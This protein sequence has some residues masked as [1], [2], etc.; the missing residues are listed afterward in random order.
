MWGEAP[1]N[2]TVTKFCMW[3]SFPGVIICARFY[4]YRPN[5][6]WEAE[7]RKLA[8]PIDLKGDLYNMQ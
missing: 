3:V 5:S 7:P 4:L 2:F 8:V 1:S 6:F